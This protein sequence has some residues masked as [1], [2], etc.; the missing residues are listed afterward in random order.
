MLRLLSDENF[1][2]PVIDGLFLRQPDLDLVRA[3]DVGLAEAEDAVLL[4][5][6]GRRKPRSVDA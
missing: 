6:G 5:M 4:G 1:N 3:I 2:G